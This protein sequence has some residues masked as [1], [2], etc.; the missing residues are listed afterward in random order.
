MIV[1]SIVQGNLTCTYAALEL[2][3]ILCNTQYLCPTKFLNLDYGILQA[4]NKPFVYYLGLL[5]KCMVS[6]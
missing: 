2:V 6:V 3:L 1:V 5:R 4:S